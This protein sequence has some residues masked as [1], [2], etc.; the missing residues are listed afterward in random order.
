[1]KISTIW[2]AFQLYNYWNERFEEMKK[3]NYVSVPRYYLADIATKEVDYFV[4][5]ILF[6]SHQRMH[7]KRQCT[8]EKGFKKKK[9]LLDLW[10]QR[11]E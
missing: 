1:M 3:L 5:Y 11:V 6:Q 4:L 8:L 9:L 10:Q 2:I 7:T